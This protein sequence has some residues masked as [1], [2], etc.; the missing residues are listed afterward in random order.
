MENMIIILAICIAAP[1]SMMLMIIDK[2]VRMPILFMIVGI[3]V[4][5]YVSELNGMIKN[6]VAMS[7]YDLT[8]TVT[9][10]TEEF[11]KMLPV[12]FFAVVFSDKKEELYVVAISVGIGFA[13]IENTYILIQ[14]VHNVTI[15]W[16]IIRGFGTGLMH[17]MCTLLVG[18]G[19]SYVHKKRKFFYVGT[20]SFISVAM[21]YHSI[22]NMLVQSKYQYI[23]A[24]LPIATYIILLAQNHW[25][26]RKLE[27]TRSEV[28]E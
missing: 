16:A 3:L 17:G 25:K 28:Y 23:G 18:I 12:L 13:I 14:N 24:M 26:K 9:P 22:F 27:R 20:F 21:V 5:L 8:I 6:N 4:A 7:F 19:V 15:L 2:K 1:L 11:F 10:I